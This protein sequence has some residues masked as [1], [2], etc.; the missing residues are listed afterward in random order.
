MRLLIVGDTPRDRCLKDLALEKGHSLP[1][2][3][4]WNFVICS[5]PRSTVPE[6]FADLLP[7]NQKVVCG[8]T[9]PGFDSLAK[10]R[11]WQLYRILEDTQFTQINAEL[12]AEG[13]VFKAMENLDKALRDTA[14]LVIGYGR[15]GKALTQK[16]RALGAQVTV[17]ARRLES[18]VEAGESSIPIEEIQSV[19]PKT[20]LI[21]NTVP[22]QLLLEN[23][24]L[25][26]KH[27]AFLLELA[28]KPYGIDMEA[29]KRLGLRCSLESGLPG[30]YCPQSAASATLDYVER[31]ADRERNLVTGGAR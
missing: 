6:E 24:L 17:A 5:L 8:L 3:G 25:L 13:A 11:N 29:A 18:R 23:G 27:T 1:T 20:D 7:E 12:T 26:C 30:R 14:C 2:Q 22:S 19:L 31:M 28:S 15:I 10:S 21:L 4:P 9:E 16:L